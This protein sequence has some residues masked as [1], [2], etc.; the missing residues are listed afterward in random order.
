MKILETF[1]GVLITGAAFCFSATHPPPLAAQTTIPTEFEGPRKS[2]QAV[3]ER[4]VAPSVTVAVARGERIIWNEAFGWADRERRREATTETPY[5]IA[6][7]TKPITAT[8]IMLLSDRGKLSLDDP[9]TSVVKR[10][11]LGPRGNTSVTLWAE[12]SPRLSRPR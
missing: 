6:S 2:L 5:S 3:V 8:A 9:V 1:L 4:S 10:S 11:S 7:V 12:L